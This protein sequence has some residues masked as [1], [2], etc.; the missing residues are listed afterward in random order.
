M[1]GISQSKATNKSGKE[2][3]FFYNKSCIM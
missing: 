3:Y 2:K 1:K